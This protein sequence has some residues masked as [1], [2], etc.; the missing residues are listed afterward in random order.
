MER[1]PGNEYG[2]IVIGAGHAGC[3]AA[4]A[5]ARN[6]SKTLLATISMDS[7]ALL[8]CNSAVGGPGRGQLVREIDAL[9]GEIGKNV[10]KSYIHSRMLNISKGPALR[11]VRAIVDKKRYFLYM[12]QVLENQE[13]LDLKQGL[14]AKIEKFG[15]KYKLIK[16]D[17]SFYIGKCIVIATGTFLRGKIFW[18]KY[19]RE[20][21]RQGEI[22]SIKLP[23]C[24]ENIGYKFGRLRTETPPRVDKKTV[25]FKNIRTQKYDELPEMF[26]F[27]NVYDG[28]EQLNNH[29][30]YI[31]KECIDFIVKNIKKSSIY[32]ISMKSEN[33]KYCPSI[34]DKVSRFKNRKRHQ[35]FIQPEGKDTNEMYL[36][37]LFTTFSEDI[38]EGI[39]KRIKGLEKAEITRP[40]YGVEYDYL[41]PGQLNI[42]LESKK[43][44]NIFFAGQI[45]GTTGYEEAAAQ[46]IIAGIN[47]SLSSWDKENIFLSREDG[48]IGILIDDVILKGVIEPYRMLTSRNEFRLYHRHD[49]ADIRMSKILRKIGHE[50]KANI[51]SKKYEKIDEAYSNIKKSKYFNSKKMIED[52][53]QDRL[54]KDNINIIKNTFNLDDKELNSLIIN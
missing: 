52:I 3:E 18:G 31:E 21:G 35:I 36:H 16:T 2:V 43:H 51:I 49:N 47:A 14:V 24:L 54:S 17:E 26:S 46:G 44:K 32:E 4:L 11:T 20:A 23:G 37:G 6:G 45:N 30:T 42:N 10:D 8:P 29:I 50:K 40:G 1:M 15:I 28:R 5:S 38:Q 27:D 25:D 7:I 33:P 53:K 39:I 13:N 9:G 48:Y 19:E 41:I 34:E 22:N 12:K